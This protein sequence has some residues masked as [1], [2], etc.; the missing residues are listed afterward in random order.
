MASHTTDLA[1][2]SLG[3]SS[4]R[5]VRLPIHLARQAVRRIDNTR[6]KR[7]L[8]TA[9]SG[10]MLGWVGV[11]YFVLGFFT[12][13]IDLFDQSLPAVADGPKPTRMVLSTDGD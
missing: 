4:N 1:R 13:P 8:M 7:G 3:L 10:L 12:S 11:G 5:V 2:V 9:Q 6:D